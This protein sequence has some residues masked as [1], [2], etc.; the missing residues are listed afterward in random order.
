MHPYHM[1]MQWDHV[2][3]GYRS[4]VVPLSS[5]L[6]TFCS[7]ALRARVLLRI[8]GAISSAPSAEPCPGGCDSRQGTLL[9]YTCVIRSLLCSPA[10][11]DSFP[12]N[13]S[14]WPPSHPLYPSSHPRVVV[15]LPRMP[16]VQAQGW[17][18][19]LECSPDQLF[20]A[21]SLSW[22][23]AWCVMLI[24]TFFFLN[25]VPFFPSKISFKAPLPKAADG[26]LWCRPGSH[27]GWP[28]PWGLGLA[29]P[30]SWWP[31]GSWA[32]FPHSQGTPSPCSLPMVG[33]P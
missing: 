22:A 26:P 24:L 20:T 8:Q 32:V 13:K 14:S 17:M 19:Q 15:F 2:E 7:V 23:W 30:R 25:W 6:C 11:P 28:M 3:E 9:S 10:L 29:L 31:L 33:A 21:P 18:A 5:L 4:W 12:K 1:N 16:A 27:T